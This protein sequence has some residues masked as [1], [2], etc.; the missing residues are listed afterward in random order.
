[1]NA[2]LKDC[3]FSE[4]AEWRMV[5]IKSTQSLS[6]RAGNSMLTPYIDVFLGEKHEVKSILKEVIVGHTPNI[7]LARESTKL[8]LCK[9]LLKQSDYPLS[10]A[11][12]DVTK[13]KIP[14]RNW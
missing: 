4:E 1:M 12:F 9:T 13:S 10:Y 14:Y 11:V 6:F 8:F 7:E 5:S 3:S 2:G